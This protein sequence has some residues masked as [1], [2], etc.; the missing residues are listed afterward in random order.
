MQLGFYI[1][2]YFPVETV[3]LCELLD[4]DNQEAKEIWSS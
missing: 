1:L 3:V 2:L 4:A